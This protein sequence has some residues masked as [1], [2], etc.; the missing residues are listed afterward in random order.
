VAETEP[1]R[2]R[3][4]LTTFGVKLIGGSLVLLST[5]SAVI[6]RHLAG[7]SSAAAA[8]MGPL[9]L[10]IVGSVLS[11]AG[12]PIYAWLVAE[13]FRH[14][15]SLGRYAAALLAVGLVSEIPYDLV[16]SGRAIDWSSQNP[17]LALPI[18]LAVLYFMDKA[19]QGRPKP[20]AAALCTVVVL[21]GIVWVLALR[22]G[23]QFGLM[24]LGVFMVALL[25]VFR[26]L[27]KR[28]N[29]MVM[30]GAAVCALPLAI[31][32]FGLIPVHLAN[33]ELGYRQPWTKWAFYVFYPAHLLLFALV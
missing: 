9:T 8:P 1:V 17:A 7:Q 19:V 10:A 21:A 28:E 26:F 6:L 12:I 30:A 16:G 3:R 2:R 13:G 18:C 23:T 33:G 27:R 29:I 4:G 32:A 25:P 15:R 24:N 22:I 20:A 5:L 14:T 31:P 11:W